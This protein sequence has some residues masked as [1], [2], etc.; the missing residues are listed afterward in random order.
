[1]GS[2]AE[3]KRKEGEILGKAV[4]DRGLAPPNQLL[5]VVRQEQLGAI[6]CAA[7]LRCL[8]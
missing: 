4:A 6:A 7:R 3:L 1:M 8:S 2:T 5:G